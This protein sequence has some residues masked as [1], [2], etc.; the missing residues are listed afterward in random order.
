MKWIL[1][2]F[3]MKWIKK[4]KTTMKWVRLQ[5]LGRESTLNKMNSNGMDQEMS[6]NARFR[7]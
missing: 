7:N 3:E 5:Q 2:P 6:I 1:H 4:M